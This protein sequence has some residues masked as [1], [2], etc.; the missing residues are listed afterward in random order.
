MRE[1][2]GWQEHARFMNALVDDGLILLGGPVEGDRETL[3]VFKSL[4]REAVLER[5]AHDPWARNGM[6]T[7]TSIENW[8]ILLCPPEVDGLI[9]TTP[10]TS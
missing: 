10:T 7:V 6:L 2:E 8:T 5:L 4:S 3:L 1:Q 9:A